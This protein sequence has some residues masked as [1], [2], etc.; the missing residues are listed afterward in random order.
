MLPVVT[1]LSTSTTDLAQVRVVCDWVQYRQNFRDVVQVRPVLCNAEAGEVSQ[2]AGAA[3]AQFEVAI[4]ARRASESPI[5]D[6]TTELLSGRNDQVFL[7]DWAPGHD[8]LIWRF[9]GLYWS[10]LEL[11]EKATGQGYE[12]ALP[13]GESDA[14]NR[15]AATELIGELF[16]VWDGLAATDALPEEL[17]IV[18]LGVGNGQQAKVFLDTFRDLDREHGRGYY[19]RLQYLMGDYSAHVLDLA[20]E[21][22]AEHAERSSAFVLDAT[23]PKSSLGFLQGKVFLIYI[24]NVYDNL[25]A[26]EVAHFGGQTHLVHNRAYLPRAA[27]DVLAESVCSS[28]EQLPTLVHKLLRLGP[29]VLSDACPEH[30]PTIEA[31]VRF[32]QDTWSALRLAE[33]YVPLRG[34][35]SYHIADSLT[36]EVLRPLL[37]SGTDVRMHSS[38][39]AVASFSDSLTL[40]HPFG[41]LVCHDIFVT[42]VEG[43]RT[44]FRGPGKYDGSVVNWVNGT[45]LAHVG[46]RRGFDVRY[47]R[48]RHRTGGNI[49]T[50]TVESRG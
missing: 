30:F 46:R 6:L 39:G 43:Y 49:V 11:W 16:D 26:D 37:E 50:M 15:D 32:W 25:P 48:F 12:Q 9:N 33:R 45:L 7:E 5:G 24:S 42:D 18:E 29:A 13:G 36:G 41:K 1:A 31:A 40:L 38:V 34:L 22:V 28:V 17:Y 20:R 4:D 14:R 10:E 8:S 47:E 23:H 27:A 3:A 2:P 19:P 44:T 21:T 35:D